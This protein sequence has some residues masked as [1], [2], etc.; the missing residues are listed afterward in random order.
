[1]SLKKKMSMGILSGALGVS[2]IGGG[3]WAAFNDVE[4][5]NN[6]L[7]A[8]T[9]DLV[10]GENTTMNFTLSNLK[11]GDYFNKSLV[12]T[13]GGSLDINQI[14]VHANKLAGW[15][16]K[17]VLDLNTEI[18]A[19]SGNNSEDDFL[20]QFKVTITKLA[21]DPANNVDVFDGTLADLVAGISVDELT[22]TD[23]TTVGLASGAQQ[24]YNV[25][26]EF[27]ED[28]T[29]FP[30]SRLHVQNKYQDEMSNLEF[31]F[32]ATQMPG[33]DRSND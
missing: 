13:N 5:V 4:V 15:T 6:T 9:L 21:V 12:L 3:T 7:A 32:E 20:S 29:T 27:V 22:D 25:Y 17:D 31:V 10:V 30:G 2:L 8:G 24:I 14:L 33:E 11:P 16:D 1:M 28:S 18:G 19:N 26:V 23:A